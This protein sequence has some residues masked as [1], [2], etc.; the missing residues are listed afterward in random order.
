MRALPSSALSSF[1]ISF[2]SMV[3][4]WILLVNLD[5]A[6]DPNGVSFFNAHQLCSRF[7]LGFRAQYQRPAPL[8]R[9]RA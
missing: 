4:L 9:L 6:S 2:T 7:R 8:P 1:F 3:T 5:F